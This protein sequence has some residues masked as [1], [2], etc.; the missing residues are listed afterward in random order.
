MLP[1]KQCT[2]REV[3]TNNF[4]VPVYSYNDNKGFLSI[5]FYYVKYFNHDTLQ[6]QDGGAHRQ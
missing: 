4:V 5:L 2:K 6:E 1:C 3:Y